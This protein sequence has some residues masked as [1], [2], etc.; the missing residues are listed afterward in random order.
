MKRPALPPGIGDRVPDLLLRLDDGAHATLSSFLGHTVVLTLQPGGAPNPADA[1]LI[2]QY[3][4]LLPPAQLRGRQ[5]EWCDV[6]H[7]DETQRLVLLAGEALGPDAGAM[8]GAPFR[9]A[10]FVLDE[11][12]QIAWRCV[13]PLGLSVDPQLLKDALSLGRKSGR[14]FPLSRRQFVAASVGVAAL[15][16]MTASPGVAAT[17]GRGAANG[18]RVDRMSAH[19]GP[20]S[21]EINGATHK[22]T[23]DPRVTLPDALRERIG[24]TGSLRDRHAPIH[25]PG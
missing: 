14:A 11:R 17:N 9:H 18:G 4:A 22:V 20:I 15:L 8:L 6:R 7:G 23:V 12:G 3:D 21:L 19:G 25:D 13:A 24:L 10:I 5:A 16:A 1:E 2:A